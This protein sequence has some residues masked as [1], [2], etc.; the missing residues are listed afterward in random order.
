M[1]RFVFYLCVAHVCRTHV[2][3]TLHIFLLQRHSSTD[4]VGPELMCWIGLCCRRSIS[5]PNSQGMLTYSDQSRR[6]QLGEPDPSNCPWPR[7][8][9]VSLTPGRCPLRRFPVPKCMRVRAMP[10]SR[11]LSAPKHHRRVGAWCPFASGVGAASPKESPRQGSFP[12]RPVPR[13]RRGVACDAHWEC[14]LCDFSGCI[15]KYAQAAPTSLD[16]EPVRPLSGQVCLT[17][18]RHRWSSP[19]PIHP[20]RAV[21]GPRRCAFHQG[22]LE[23]MLRDFCQAWPAS[24]KLWRNSGR[25]LVTF[26]PVRSGFDQIWG[27]LDRKWSDSDKMSELCECNSTL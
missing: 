13:Q 22:R 18:G 23:P 9:Q 14:G 20:I 17:S 10:A 15:P 3:C 5:S 12:L 21:V 8:P 19:K 2:L 4:S 7:R 26:C 6:G 24:G 27:N 16:I 25:L 11:F 1:R